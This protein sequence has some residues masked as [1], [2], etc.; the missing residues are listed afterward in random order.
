ARCGSRGWRRR[1]GAHPRTNPRGNPAGPDDAGDGRLRIFGRIAQE[2]AVA[3]HPGG[4]DHGD[5]PGGAGPPAPGRTDPARPRKRRLR[6]RGIGAGDTP[7]SRAVP[8]PLKR[9]TAYTTNEHEWTRIRTS[10]ER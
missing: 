9:P 4:G 2:R 1:P 8:R 10:S 3:T 6:A 5:G 7:D